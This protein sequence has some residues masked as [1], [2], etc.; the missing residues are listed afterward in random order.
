MQVAQKLYEAGFITY[1]RTDS[2]N[3]SEFAIQAA[4]QEISTRYGKDYSKPT[5]YTTKSK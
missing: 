2:V 1:M 3:L 4:Q 5:H